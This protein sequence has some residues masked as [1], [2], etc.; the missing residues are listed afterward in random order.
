M[1]VNDMSWLIEASRK[2]QEKR[3]QFA[4]PSISQHIPTGFT[5]LGEQRQPAFKMPLSPREK[6]GQIIEQMRQEQAQRPVVPTLSAKR[7]MEDIRSQQEAEKLAR[8]Q[9]AYQLERDKLADERYERE[10]Q[11][12]VAQDA[13]A[14]AA[15][16]RAAGGGAAT[17]GLTGLFNTLGQ[18]AATANYQR[19]VQNAIAGGESL[20]TIAKDIIDAY[21]E[22]VY[23]NVNPAD[24]LRFAIAQFGQQY[25]SQR[26]QPGMTTDIK[27]FQNYKWYLDN[28]DKLWKQAD[29][30][31]RQFKPEAPATGAE[32]LTAA[33]RQRIAEILGI[34]V[35]DVDLYIRTNPALI[36]QL[37]GKQY[38][39]DSDELQDIMN[40][41][42]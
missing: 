2:A 11:Y 39:S 6:A 18:A 10:W 14:N 15:K 12:K 38:G 4:S 7:L 27:W 22:M 17:A 8:E 1:A 35:T 36:S 28:K 9:W 13:I 21:P 26:W 23:D 42:P 3:Q 19:I 41:R 20:E 29:A 25:E 34:P 37:L 40:Y 32:A 16:A 5:G 31:E 30:L 24:I 33:E